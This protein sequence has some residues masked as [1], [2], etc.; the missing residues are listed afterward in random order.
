MVRSRFE[1]LPTRRDYAKTAPCAP[2][3]VRLPGGIER[4]DFQMF[5]HVDVQTAILALW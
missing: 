5:N 2:S 1:S 4:L 3:H